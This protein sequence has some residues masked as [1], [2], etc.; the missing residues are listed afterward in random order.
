MLASTSEMTQGTGD[1]LPL[2][3]RSGGLVGSGAGVCCGGWSG[4]WSV[5]GAGV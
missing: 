1:W 3:G 5:I 2:W 4:F